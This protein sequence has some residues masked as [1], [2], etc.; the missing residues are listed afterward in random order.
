MRFAALELAKMPPFRPG[1]AVALSVLILVACSDTET[2][3]PRP[4]PEETAVDYPVADQRPHKLTAHGHTRVDPYYWLRDDQRENPDVLAYLEAENAYTRRKLA[5]T[6]ALQEKLYREMVG[7]IEQDD[8]SVPYRLG[9]YWYYTRFERGKE[10]PVYARRKGSLEAPEEV[11]LDA[12]GLARGHE[13]YQI[14]NFQVSPNGQLLAYAEDTVSRGQYTIR[15]KNLRTGELYPEPIADAAAD[16]AW[17]NDDKTL[18]YVRLQEGTLIPYQAY[19]HAL[20]TDPAR[21][22]LVYEETDNTFNMSLDKSRSREQIVLSLDSTLSSEVRLL[23]ADRPDSGFEAFLPREADHEYSVEPLGQV[24]YIRTNWQAENFRLMR[25]PLASA[26]DKATWQELVPHRQAVFLNDFT[27]FDDYLVVEE[28]D[29][30]VLKLRV[31]P[32]AGEG[33]DFFIDSDETAYTAA[34]DDNPN[35]N[36]TVLRYAYTSLATPDT[37]YDYDMAAGKRTLR[38]RQA[39]LGGFERDDYLT[40]RIHAPARDG[41]SIPVTLYH[42]DEVSNDG[43]A[44]LYVFGYGS[45]G[46]SYDPEFRAYRLSLVDRGFVIALAHIRGG[47]E[48]GRE[49]YED[50][51]LLAKKNTFT[52]FIDVTE[53]L[54]AAGWG[55][56]DKVVA[57]GRSAGGLLMGAIANMRPDLYRIVMAGVPFVDVVTTMLDESIPLTTFEFDEWGNPQDPEYYQYMLSYSP[58]DQISAQRYPDLLVTTGLWDPA[59]QYWEPAKWVARLR[60]RKTDSNPLLMYC[61]METG[62]GGASG[63][64]DRYKETAMEWA[65]LLDLAGKAESVLKG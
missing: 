20:G 44:P 2:E 17:A 64:F 24:A 61:N 50:G 7:R 26:A 52:D 42:R 18:F 3:A 6:E 40:T 37:I 47:Q 59:V 46:N 9:D 29:E 19:R 23:D 43:T 25:A 54:I 58:Y 55:D 1:S 48:L 57:S 65:F 22:Q 31:I 33:E 8:E 15:I 60:D 5:H 21:D 32:L 34:I 28:R 16:L 10:H 14:G 63:R 27:V 12:N 38:K 62:H 56:P 45:Y 11:L 4:T 53:H 36:T 39:V 49:W 13:F 51:K 41:A 35:T 30:G